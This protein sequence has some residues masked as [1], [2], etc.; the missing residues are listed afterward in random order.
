MSSARLVELSRLLSF[1]LRHEP[2]KFGLVLDAEGFVS[3]EDTLR[4]VRSH[5]PRA[6]EA[7]IVAVIEQV[8]PD[9]RRFSIVDRDIR[10]NY[11]HSLSERIRHEAVTPPARLLH[12]TNAAAIEVILRSGLAPM[13]RQYVHLTTSIELASRVG[14]R[15]GKPVIL[16]VDAGAA[17]RDGVRFYRANESFWLADSVPASYLALASASPADR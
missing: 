13:N 14:A 16:Q 12:G 5:L 15:R 8:E 4:A 9:K 6:S 1:M 17:H 11:G 2:A 10:A 3:L 7:D